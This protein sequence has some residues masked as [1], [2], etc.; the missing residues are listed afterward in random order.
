MESRRLV[1][2]ELEKVNGGDFYPQPGRPG[3]VIPTGNQP[4]YRAIGYKVRCSCC[5]TT[6]EIRLLPNGEYWG[7]IWCCSRMMEKV[8]P[9]FP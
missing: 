2:K 7:P 6:G 5:G 4:T 9:I 1:N 3:A 8:E